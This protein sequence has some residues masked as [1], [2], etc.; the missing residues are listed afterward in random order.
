M[1]LVVAVTLTICAAVLLALFLTHA[2]T[3]W[4]DEVSSVHTQQAPTLAEM[5]QRAEFESFP[6]LWMLLLRGW[7]AIGGGSSDATLRTFGLI[8]PIALI[9]GV[10]MA[11]WRIGRAAPIL[12]LALVALNT[13]ILR[14]AATLRPWGLGAGLAL[15]T[16]AVMWDAIR[17]P[18]RRRI[19]VA[20]IVALL[21]VHCLFQNS[22]FLAATAAGAAAAAWR[23]GRP[24]LAIIPIA[25]GALCALSLI[26]YAGIIQR[27]SDW[28]ALGMGPITV[29]EMASTLTWVLQT[30]GT[31]ASIVAGV[32]V[33]AAVLLSA[34]AWNRSGSDDIDRQRDVAVYAGTTIIV[35]GVGLFL[36]YSRL[37]Y[38]T[39]S[40]YYLGLISVWAVCA[41]L[42]IRSV[43]RPRVAIPALTIAA[44][45]VVVTGATGAWQAMH[46]RQTNVDVIAGR[47]H[48]E[49]GPQDLILVNPWY[50]GVTLSRYYRG[51]SQVMTIPPIGDRTISR[52]DLLKEQMLTADAT[53]PVRQAIDRALSSGGR[54][55]LVGGL[56]APPPGVDIPA[57]LPPPPL[58]DTEWNSMPYELLWSKQ[59]AFWLGKRVNTCSPIDLGVPGGRLENAFLVVCAGWR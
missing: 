39:Q 28:N 44:V 51:K 8:G 20:A 31:L 41:E 26:P 7:L 2:P 46:E 55:W 15:A 49:A 21:S 37:G 40:W 5:W 48:A 16:A 3:L 45:A 56:L 10:W 59:V 38:P 13:E 36:L 12:S 24:R 57:S 11:T 54:V 35:S 42:A 19:I 1:D 18:T 30:P 6:A 52:Y 25:I 33:A 43:V 27:R 32:V 4:R 50:L 9:A 29:G 58:P 17:E 34:F 14:W 47:L 53:A 23:A 22:V